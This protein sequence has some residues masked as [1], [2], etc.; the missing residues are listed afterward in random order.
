MKPWF[1]T[2]FVI[3]FFLTGCVGVPQPTATAT[4]PTLTAVQVDD[5][6][7]RTVD[8]LCGVV[9]QADFQVGSAT[10]EQAKEWLA[11]HVEA[12]QTRDEPP[13]VTYFWQDSMS[14]VRVGFHDDKLLAA[15]RE[16]FT[17]PIY[18]GQIVAGLGPPEMVEGRLG[19]LTCEVGCPFAISLY[20]PRLGII[21]D[22]FGQ[23]GNIFKKNGVFAMKLRNNIIVSS[24][25]CFSPNRMDEF[26]TYGFQDPIK[27]KQ[28]YLNDWQGF[29]MTVPLPP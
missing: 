13:P 7:P 28:A 19:W 27:L 15:W 14:R 24:V 8:E 10:M 4:P 23:D 25:T 1:A 26:L 11:Q 17:D 20:Y 2:T 22:S 18:L 9:N 6:T 3:V 16:E 5:L 21:V 12:F 29:D